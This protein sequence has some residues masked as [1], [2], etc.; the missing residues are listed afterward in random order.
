MICRKAVI[1][2]DF[3]MLATAMREER[4]IGVRY[5]RCRKK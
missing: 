3:T 4:Q 5:D 1:N 2:A